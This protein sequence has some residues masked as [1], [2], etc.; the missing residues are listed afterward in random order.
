MHQLRRKNVISPSA[1]P[2]PLA[3]SSVGERRFVRHIGLHHFAH[4][5]EVVEGLD[6]TQCAARYLGTE[7]GRL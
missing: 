2:F 5:R 6:V 3:S 1:P 7:R 4:L